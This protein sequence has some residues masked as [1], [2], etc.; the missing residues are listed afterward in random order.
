[1]KRWLALLMI[2]ALLTVCGAPAL[3]DVRRGDRG[4]EVRYLQWLLMQDGW[5]FE[6]P[7][8]IFGGPTEQAVRDYQAYCGL[9]ENGV[10]DHALMYRL[11]QDRIRLMKQHYG[12]D[13]YEPYPGNYTPPFETGV[14]ALNDPVPGCTTT[15]LRDS[16]SRDYCPEHA[17]I[18][19]QEAALT[20]DG[21][22]GGWAEA[23]NLWSAAVA[24]LC[25]QWLA[26]YPDTM[27][28]DILACWTA[29]EAYVMETGSA[30]YA[31]GL[32]AAAVERQLCLMRRCFAGS[33]CEKADGLP[34]DRNRD[35]LVEEE[36]IGYGAACWASTDGE[37]GM[38][39]LYCCDVHAAMLNREYERYFIESDPLEGVDAVAAE[40][41]AA[42]DALFD[43]W[44]AGA[45]EGA[46]RAQERFHDMLDAMDAAS[47]SAVGQL[48]V[49][50]W[51]CGRL[52][53]WLN[54]G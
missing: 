44:A 45:P 12:N 20:A 16:M 51:E 14:D 29:W 22:A 11:D 34:Y 27:K 9:E 7:D 37:N 3:A 13:Y 50:Q 10:A 19:A 43:R 33:L 28:L 8:G 24:R 46:R 49:L 48:R 42:V 54:E 17:A 23:G 35:F 38:D 26:S 30:M 18:L 5:L 4:E 53:A 36:H 39:W 47:G 31:M 21:S 32:D 15:A 2:A 1:M 6:E 25:G 40:W 52:C 41:R